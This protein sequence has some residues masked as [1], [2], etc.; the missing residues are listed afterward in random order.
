M[1]LQEIRL[2][3]FKSFADPADLVIGTG[4]TGV[5]GPNGCGK[6]N[7]VEAIL[8]AMGESAPTSVRSAEMDEVIFAGG[9]GRP[10]RNTAEV[11]LLVAPGGRPPIPTP[12]LNGGARPLNGED[13]EITRRIARKAGSVYRING[14]EVRARDVHTLFGDAGGG[15]RSCAIV[16]QNRI[17]EL[18][19]AKPAARRQLIED[20]AGVSGLHQRRREVELRINA[21]V[22][23]L[24]A[25]DGQLATLDRQIAGLKRESRRARRYREIAD[26]LRK[27]ELLLA[28]SQ[29]RDA[30]AVSTAIQHDLAAAAAESARATAA[31]AGAETAHGE[32]AD[33]LP[34]LRRRQ[35]QAS[36]AFARIENEEA[37][38]AERIRTAERNAETH[39][40]R[41]EQLQ[42][43]L[44]RER[45]LAADAEETLERLAM[46]EAARPDNAGRDLRT[47]LAE[48]QQR[49]AACEAPLADAETALDA[50]NRAAASL[51]ARHRQ[52]FE[53]RSEA[54]TSI[55][56]LDNEIRSAASALAGAEEE[57]ERASEAASRTIE[58]VGRAQRAAD[59]AGQD[60][61]RHEDARARTEQ[62]ERAARATHAAAAQRL[63]ELAAERSALEGVLATPEN[64]GRPVLACIKARPGTEIALGAALGE[65]LQL[66]EV[67]SGSGASGWVRLGT[68]RAAAPLPEGVRPLSDFVA[69]PDTLEA[70]LRNTGLVEGGKG[71]ALQDSLRPG[72]SLVSAEG[73]I[74]RWDGLHVASDRTGGDAARRVAARSRIACLDRE[75]LE[76]RDAMQ[77]SERLLKERTL[78]LARHVEATQQS[79]TA[80]RKAEAALAAGSHSRAIARSRLELLEAR[81]DTL[82]DSRSRAVASKVRGEQH[83][84]ALDEE[85]ASLNSPD[86]LVARSEGARKRV[87]CLRG[88]ALARAA[89]CE[90]LKNALASL[91]AERERRRAERTDWRRRREAALGRCRD[92]Q[93]RIS[94]AQTALKSARET[95]PALV[96]RRSRLASLLDTARRERS[97]AEDDLAGAEQA[98]QEAARRTRSSEARLT[99]AREKSARLEER[100]DNARSR[101]TEAAARLR[102]VSGFEP[103]SVSARAGLEAESVSAAKAY[104]EQV[105]ALRRERDRVGPVNLRA[106]TELA[107]LEESRQTLA[108]EHDDLAAALARFNQAIQTINAEGRKRLEEA[109]DEV[110]RHFR[111]MFVS[112]FGDGASASLALINSDDPFE[113]GLEIYAQPPGKRLLSL[114]QMSGGEKALTA[115]ALIFALFLSSPAPVCVLDEVD[116]PLDDANVQRFCDMLEEIAACTDTNFLVITHHALTISRMDRLYGVTMAERG[117]SQLVSVNYSEAA[118]RLTA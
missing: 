51:A 93:D 60:A 106:D 61:I 23:N 117:V 69:A 40:A 78:D 18:V 4:I 3:G 29:W 118:L 92:I 81:L 62:A 115:L 31:A 35:Q 49:A 101:S 107:A 15:A 53:R 72:Q 88:E 47:E 74:W 33:R 58:N 20:A 32:A 91:E 10:A 95:G 38:L 12:A 6:S 109:F 52:I 67:D 79:R 39:A 102:E 7:I 68:G 9:A 116:A 48:A 30:Q 16:R 42:S 24:E 28:F 54:N 11:S 114:S 50:L 2:R 26:R 46:E 85:L 94:E 44:T 110:N 96:E 5:V 80:L 98:L 84:A 43:D 22:R 105:S 36:A 71:D 70:R 41:I 112:L 73:E 8:W 17:G 90:R 108:S 25:V 45:Q 97:L 77:A 104:E 1:R 21:T 13:L 55:A 65:W 76:A 75:I 82:R 64:G 113:A 34:P 63:A 66:P 57:R 99:E 111:D 86:T 83:I 100:A 87:A 14:R 19:N 27:T 37:G 89:E 56:H 59:D 103:E